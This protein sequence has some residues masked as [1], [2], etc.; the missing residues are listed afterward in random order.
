MILLLPLIFTA[1]LPLQEAEPVAK[2]T[3]VFGR[4]MSDF[5]L[6]DGADGSRK[7]AEFRRVRLGSK[8]DLSAFASYK[9][10]LE[11]AAGD[12]DDFNGVEA[13][14]GEAEALR[15]LRNTWRPFGADAYKALD[16]QRADAGRLRKQA[17]VGVRELLDRFQ[18][19]LK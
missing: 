12:E 6:S 16:R 19:S 1:P 18:V 11:F 10:E 13:V 14:E 17:S 15:V 3:H 4:V 7:G 8:G 2:S 5:T 9:V